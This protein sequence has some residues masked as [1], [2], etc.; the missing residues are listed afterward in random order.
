MH[1][2]FSRISRYLN[3]L[4]MIHAWQYSPIYWIVLNK[5]RWVKFC[6]NKHL[7][8]LKN[9]LKNKKNSTSLLLELMN[10]ILRR[11]IFII[12]FVIILE[13]ID[14]LCQGQSWT[15]ARLL[16][17][18]III[19]PQSYANYIRTLAQIAGI[20]L[21]LYFT[22]VNVVSSTIYSK[23]S[24]DIRDLFIREVSNNIY[25]Q[26]IITF[27]IA[28]I[29]SLSTSTLGYQ[30]GHL[31]FYFLIILG[32]LVVVGFFIYGLKA[33]FL[34][35][36]SRL[37]TPLISD[38]LSWLQAVS[39]KGFKWQ[40]QSFQAF[41][42][43][44]AEAAL[45]TYYNIIQMVG[46]DE[47]LQL[48]SLLR[49]GVKALNLLQIYAQIKPCIPSE[50][51][52]YRRI[53][54]HQDW[55]ASESS[56][57]D[58]AM[59]TGTII[60][61]KAKPDM[62]WFESDIE[63]IV[64]SALKNLINHEDYNNAYK[65]EDSLWRTLDI[66]A[67]NLSID[68][69]FHLFNAM[70]E[71]VFIQAHNTKI[72]LTNLS[73]N[74]QDLRPIIGLIDLYGLA[75]ISIILGLS[76]RIMAM[77]SESFGKSI[78]EINWDRPNDIYEK[79]FPRPIIQ[80][81]EQIQKGLKFEIAVEGQII[82]PLW[83]QQQ[84]AVRSLMTFLT[85]AIERLVDELESSFDKEAELLIKEKRYIIAA[86]LI[87]RGLEA[88]SKFDNN[89]GDAKSSFESFDKLRKIDDIKWPL[90]KWEEL[91]VRINAIRENLVLSSAK[92]LYPLAELNLSESIP[93]Y[94]GQ[95]YFLVA[96]ECYNTM[97]SGNENR[98]KEIFP[99][100]FIACL[101]AHDRETT[102]LENC[103][104]NIRFGISNEPFLDLFAISG[105]AIIYSELDSK[106][107]WNL[108]KPLWDNYYIDHK[109]DAMPLSK[110]FKA[111]FDYSRSI[112]SMYTFPYQHSSLRLEWKKDLEQQL[113]NHG[114]LE[115][116]DTY[117]PRKNE[118][119]K[120]NHPS[121]IIRVI[122]RKNL[123]FVELEEFF[124]ALY[125][126][127]RPEAKEINWSRTTLI[128]LANSFNEESGNP[129]T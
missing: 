62:M 93:D 48:E 65:L 1:F 92:I 103:D 125:I 20:F 53:I 105:V 10:L 115:D 80:D 126:M 5:I 78:A 81:L 118:L 74:E 68:E 49:F 11:S 72:D 77:N 71:I 14:N 9:G 73:K 42:Q 12:L 113:N 98:F 57:I 64:I 88:C 91:D 44:N 104:S 54:Q 123:D 100:F 69:S 16:K 85:K 51:F 13:A 38:I 109:D 83:Y 82:S 45:R 28:T 33:F 56:T 114:L 84:L 22:A 106:N 124:F 3:R 95:G 21:G 117:Y 43:R 47:H 18:S 116:D 37:S 111:V 55:L 101:C 36:P 86:E 61:P 90:P 24:G 67:E 122:A 29:V 96:D 26:L 50:S 108:V 41:H 107:F 87:Q 19:D 120:L 59:Q 2:R 76:R 121:E 30:L 4:Q 17:I 15:L 25:L 39:P 79:A 6:V 8:S 129:N 27:I 127:R 58:L 7:L 119:P 40:D 110:Y 34:F 70:K 94:F 46:S 75:L 66:L 60:R 128:D 35:D 52:W 31:N 32:F 102:R 23:V 99:H 63:K 112:N 89:F 97:K